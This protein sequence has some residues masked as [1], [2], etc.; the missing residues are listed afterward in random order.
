VKRTIST[1]SAILAVLLAACETPGLDLEPIFVN[2]RAVAPSGDTLLAMT[3]PGSPGVMLY[4][5][6]TNSSEILGEDVLNS[7]AHLQWVNDHVYV[8]DILDGQPTILVLSPTGQVVRR[9]ALDQSA[10]AAHQFAVLPDQQI[11]I[12]TKDDR[13]M[14]IGD[15]ST[16]TFALTDASPRTGFLVA[17]RGGVLHAVPDRALTLYNGLGK[18]RWRI[19]WPWHESAFVADLA[20]DSQGRPLVLAGQEG[21]DGFVVFGLDAVTG[22]VSRWMEGPSSTFSIRRYGEIRPDTAS[23]WLGGN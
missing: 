12:E 5:R 4:D 3:I 21:S 18:I 11:V 16:R 2:G 9:V 23:R 10:A 14:A 6:R 1:L 15:D 13:L 7:P 17:A 20:V 8:S 22:E 19:D